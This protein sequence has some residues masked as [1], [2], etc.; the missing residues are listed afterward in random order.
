[1]DI[2]QITVGELIEMLKDLE[3]TSVVKVKKYSCGTTFTELL[4]KEEI[5][6]DE[7]G[8]TLLMDFN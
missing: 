8:V 6:I 3:H 7:S 4:Q 5:R 1:M 2:S